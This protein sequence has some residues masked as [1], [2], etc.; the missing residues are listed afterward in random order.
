MIAGGLYAHHSLAAEYDQNKPVT[1]H[2]VFT[3]ID[4]RNPHAFLY[5]DVKGENGAVVK[6]QC[7]LGSPNALTRAG[8]SPDAAKA[9]DELVVEGLLARDGSRTCSTRNV[10]FKDGRILFNQGQGPA[11]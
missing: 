4:W 8:W 9:G 11:R 7:E 10:K 5:L 3:S 1:L 2:A 6:W